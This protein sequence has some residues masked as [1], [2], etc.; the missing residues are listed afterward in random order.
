MHS[1]NAINNLL[2]ELEKLPGIGPKSATRIAYFLVNDNRGDAISLARSI[3]EVKETVHFC[4]YCFNY[5]Q[6]DVCPICAD[7]SR[8]QKLIC[9]VA[10][11]KNIPPIERTGAF[12]GLY[13][14]LGG[15]ISPMDG[16]SATDLHINEL[17]D[18]VKDNG[19]DEVL[20]A[21]NPNIEGELT[22][23]WIANE[24]QGLGVK[25]TRPASGIPVGGEIE[26]ADEMTLARA[27]DD[28]KE[29]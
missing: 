12:K 4:N 9:V 5:S 7:K 25:V 22:A 3:E 8:N 19:V 18:R 6:S 29:L 11:P 27:I 13:H 10:E 14:V 20:V 26:F 15:E 16:V 2:I 28:R 21:T 1:Q 23:N 24:L 17:I